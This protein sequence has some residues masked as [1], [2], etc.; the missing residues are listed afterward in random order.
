[1]TEPDGYEW[2]FDPLELCKKVTELELRIL[3]LEDKK[4][5]EK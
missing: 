3:Q 1:M 5:I 2:I 4:E